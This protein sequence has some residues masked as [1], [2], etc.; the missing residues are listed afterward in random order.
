MYPATNSPSASGNQMECD[1]SRLYTYKKY[2]DKGKN[3]NRVFHFVFEN[4]TI[5]TKLNDQQR[6][7]L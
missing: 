1:E 2:C 5:S 6:L 7:K 4:S 3:A